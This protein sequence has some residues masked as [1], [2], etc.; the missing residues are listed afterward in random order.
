MTLGMGLMILGPMFLLFFIGVPVAY[1]I[2]AATIFVLLCTSDASLL[3][4]PQRLYSVLDSFVYIAI[5]LFIFSGYLMDIGGISKRIFSWAKAFF[6]RIPG[7]MG[8]ITLICC[9]VFAALTG[10]VLATVV[11]I[12]ALSYTSLVEDGYSKERASGLI[13]AGGTLG[14]IIP[15]SIAMIVYGASMNV[16]IPSMF[17]GAIAPGL[18]LLVLMIGV[19][20]YYVKKNGLNIRVER[21]TWKEKGKATWR[22][23]GALALPVIVLGGIYGGIFTPTEAGCVS[24][25][26]CTI[27]AYLYK[28]LNF[29]KFVDCA[30]KTVKTTAAIILIVAAANAFAWIL[31]WTR[32][33]LYA[34]QAVAPLLGGSQILYMLI[35][36]VI[37]FIAGA[38]IETTAS[39]LILAPILVPIGVS[40][41]ID[42]LFLGIVYCINLCVGYATPPFGMALFTMSSAANV[43]YAS[44]VKGI[45][46]LLIAMVVGVV[47]VALCPQIVMFL[48]NLVN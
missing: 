15:P 29:R 48:P 3:I 47:I 43:P 31:S 46:P 20:T 33:P 25:V 24:A 7:G 28:E 19:N 37:L 34:A 26:Y 22:S 27:L 16:S 40:L 30:K 36:M 2:G 12:T 8:T 9:A 6:W 38:L 13:A 18:F 35:L 44:V 1:A 42:P 17:L 5:P 11:A 39:I 21:S 14:P 10:S 32:L 41:G 4:V 45:W 23:V